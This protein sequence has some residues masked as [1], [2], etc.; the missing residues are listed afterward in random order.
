MVNII[1]SKKTKFKEVTEALERHHRGTL[2]K[3]YYS[4]KGNLFPSAILGG[5]PNRAEKRNQKKDKEAEEK[6]IEKIKEKSKNIKKEK[7]KLTTEEL[8]KYENMGI[9]HGRQG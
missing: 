3:S 6:G 8:K 9:Y 7:I 2:P 5:N 1:K 4:E